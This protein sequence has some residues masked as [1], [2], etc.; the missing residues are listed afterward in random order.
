MKHDSFNESA[1][2]YL[3]AVTEMAVPGNPVPISALA[4]RLGVSSV[5]ATEMVH[6]LSA[7]GLV[8]HTRYQGVDLTDLGSQQAAAVV[9]SHR[10]WERFL[11]D[12]LGLP[13]DTVHDM[14][15]RLEHAT[16]PDVAD[17]LDAFL[18]FPATCPHGNPIPDPE[19]FSC[20]VADF[21]LASLAPEQRAIISRIYP[22]TDALLAYLASQGLQAGTEVMM[23]EVMPFGGPLVV[24]VAAEL[25]YVGPEAADHIFVRLRWSICMSHWP[26]VL[27]LGLISVLLSFSADARR[28]QAALV[29]ASVAA[30]TQ[31]GHRRAISS[32]A[33]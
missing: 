19:G 18:G 1:E 17:A 5:S 9:R 22:E 28:S 29:S 2:M 6:R 11:A 24:S 20:A 21:P 31:C 27:A 3:K 14:A 26:V 4:E 12:C 16:D 23:H 15:C 33:P 25:R 8:A 10:L 32:I 7:Q 30:V 13:W